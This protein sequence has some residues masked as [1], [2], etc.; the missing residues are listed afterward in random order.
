MFAK[1]SIQAFVVATLELQ[2]VT[3][4]ILVSVVV[5]CDT[6]SLNTGVL[7]ELLFKKIS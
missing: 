4:A 3:H 2:L 6:F 7:C 5:Q 1:L